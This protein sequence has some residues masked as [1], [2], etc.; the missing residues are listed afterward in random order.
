[1]AAIYDQLGVRTVVNGV[2]PATRLGGTT[3]DPEVLDAMAQAASACVRIDEL[4]QRAG[5]VIAALT[6]AEAGYVTCG[7]AAALALA[8]AACITRLDAMRINRLPDVEGMPCEIIVQ[9][10]QRYDY[11]HAFRSVGARLV[12]VGFPDLTFPYEVEQA[13]GPRTAAIAYYP[14]PSRPAL[15]LAEIVAIAHRHS[16]PVIVD[17]ALEL[18]PTAGLRTFIA[19]G[20]DLVAFSGGKAIRGPQATGFLCGRAELIRAVAFNHQDMDVRPQ[21]WAYRHLIDAGQVVGPPHHGIGRAMKVGKEEIV[22]LVVALQRFVARDEVA[23]M[24]RWRACIQ[25]VLDAVR[26]TPGVHAEAIDT[27]GSGVPLACI[28]LDEAAIG[29]TAYEVLN[30]LQDGVPSVFLNEERAW[31]ADIIVNPMAMRPGDEYVIATRLQST[32]DSSGTRMASAR[33]GLGRLT[34]KTSGSDN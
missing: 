1:M 7:A 15:P 24:D 9:R 19:A 30:A 31:Q 10:T 16:I 34:E 8:A 23:E 33:N 3:L 28:H 4:Q 32:L 11:D 25:V 21:T 17:A 20:A 13:I 5:H 12:E 14:T 27:P 22:G 29:L 18:P 6:G 2:G 26:D